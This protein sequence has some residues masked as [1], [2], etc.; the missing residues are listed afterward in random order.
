MAI[1]DSKYREERQDSRN[2]SKILST[3]F[4]EEIQGSQSREEKTIKYT[5]LAEEKLNYSK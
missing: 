5:S 3:K 1:V 4:S 2:L